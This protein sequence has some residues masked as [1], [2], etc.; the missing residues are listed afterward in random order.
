MS[1]DSTPA[2][3]GTSVVKE[4][5]DVFPILL[6][7]GLCGFCNGTV[8]FILKRD[9]SGVMKFAPLQ[10][11]TAR[12]VLERHPEVRGVDSLVLVERDLEGRELVAVRSEAVIRITRY[13]GGVW[14]IAA[15][16]RVVPRP[17]RDWG[18][19]LFARWRYRLFGRYDACPVPLAGVRAR[20]LP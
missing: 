17:L 12:A 19:A 16:G 15:I 7:D 8:Q 6:Y 18:Y 4:M 14:T 11:P 20:F 1:S 13:L 2:H 10:G 5:H 3:R 9:R